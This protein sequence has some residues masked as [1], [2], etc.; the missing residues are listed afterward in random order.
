MNNESPEVPLLFTPIK[1]RGITARNRIVSSP[2]CQ[3]ASDDGGPEEWQLVNFGRFAMGGCGIVFTEE[4]AVPDAW[5]IVDGTPRPIARG[6]GGRRRPRV[7]T[8]T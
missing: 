8:S 2:M 3:Y 1:L 6:P 7:P 5:S 4:T